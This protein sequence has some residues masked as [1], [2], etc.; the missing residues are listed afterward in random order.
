MKKRIEK[1]GNELKSNRLPRGPLS[2]YD[3]VKTT[4]ET[5]MMVP[6]E[7]MTNFKKTEF[8]VEE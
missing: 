6:G 8:R 2:A 3:H 4:N 7:G 5:M 1:L